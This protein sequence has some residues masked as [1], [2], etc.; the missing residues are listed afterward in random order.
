MLALAT[1][2]RVG[3]GCCDTRSV[4]WNRIQ[5]DFAENDL[6]RARMAVGDASDVELEVLLH[7]GRRIAEAVEREAHRRGVDEIVVADPGSCGLPR[8]EQRRLLA[9]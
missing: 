8:R 9:A 5:R 3:R 1:E 2:E 6:M 4:L 7:S